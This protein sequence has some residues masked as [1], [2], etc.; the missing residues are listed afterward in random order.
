[1]SARTSQPSDDSPQVQG[2]NSM[3]QQSGTSIETFAEAEF[4]RTRRKTPSDHSCLQ[5]VQL[6][7]V[8]KKKESHLK[9]I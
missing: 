6:N 1:M 8:I 4:K 3:R 9:Q 5:F 7:G 2:R